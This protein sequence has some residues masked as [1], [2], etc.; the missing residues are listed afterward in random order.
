MTL[1]ERLKLLFEE[2]LAGDAGM[3]GRHGRARRN[4]P[5]DRHGGVRLVCGQQVILSEADEPLDPEL[6]ATGSVPP[7]PL[8]PAEPPLP[9]LSPQPAAAPAR[10]KKRNGFR[11]F[12]LI[13]LALLRHLVT[14]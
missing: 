4:E 7:L 1:K 12:L 3:F 8:E 9:V 11:E 6:P 10:T 13:L 2:I 14:R 5:R